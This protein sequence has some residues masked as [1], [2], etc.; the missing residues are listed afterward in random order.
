MIPVFALGRAQ[1]VCILL[2]TYWSRTKNKVPI[3]FAAGLISKANFYYKLFVN[4]EN[5]KLKNSFVE[6]NMFEFKYI[7]SFDRNLIKSPEP[8]VLLA[9]PGMLHG[10]LSMQVFKEWCSEPKNTL[11]IPGYCVAG[12]LGNKLLSGMK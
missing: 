8:M 4:W 7:S 1:E 9:T 2:E 10:G 3:Y 5:E 11:I 12:T 6:N